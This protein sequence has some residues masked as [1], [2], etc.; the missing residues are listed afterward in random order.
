MNKPLSM[1]IEDFKNE[2]G[3]AITQSELPPTIL[4]MIFKDMYR[5]VY[6]LSEKYR[7]E[8]ANKYNQ[9]LLK[10]KEEENKNDD[11][12]IVEE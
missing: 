3:R 6:E 2:I 4:E 11:V 8:E 12:E 7:Y 10:Q 9:E 1:V 5:N